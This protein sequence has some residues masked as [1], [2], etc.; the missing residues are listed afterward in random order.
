MS[1]Y[2]NVL[3]L[4]FEDQDAKDEA[5]GD[6][7]KVQYERRIRD[8]FT[9]IRT[10]NSKAVV[11]SVVLQKLMLD[12]SPQKINEQLN[13]VDLTGKT[14]HKI[15]VRARIPASGLI[16]I[17][18]VIIGIRLQTWMRVIVDVDV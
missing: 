12:R 2:V 17:R 5:Y 1:G 15:I 18:M 14:D 10:L 4:R 9:Q 7:E 6:L 13:A 8:I 3:N 16:G 11:T